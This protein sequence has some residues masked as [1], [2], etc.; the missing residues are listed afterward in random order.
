[1][2]ARS[3]PPSVGRHEDEHLRR[4]LR[5]RRAGDPVEM[6]RCWEELV[7]DFRDRMDGLVAVT[8]K[9]RLS[10]F[11][12]EDAVQRAM[13]RFSEKLMGTFHG[14]SMGELVNATKKLCWYACV[15]V[16]E[17][18]AEHRRR[19]T[20]LDTATV[21]DDRPAPKW[22]ADAARDAFARETEE[23]DLDSFL[24]WALPQVLASRRAVVERTFAGV[25]L[26]E[27]YAEL[28]LSRDNAYQ[29]RSRGLK[30]LAKL[31][32]EYDR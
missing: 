4:F 30:D 22:E 9:G 11:E 5:A 20:S 29:L 27:I 32:L 2:A 23:R 6:R 24:A 18:A 19:H 3:D 1:M 12:H 31:H 13:V 14:T 8:H 25:P 16:Q 7:I 17:A 28:G 15:D 10:D 26:A 21:E